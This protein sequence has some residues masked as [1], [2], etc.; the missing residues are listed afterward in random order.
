MGWFHFNGQFHPGWFCK[1][2]LGM[3][4]LGSCFVKPPSREWFHIKGDLQNDMWGCFMLRVICWNALQGYF[5][6]EDVL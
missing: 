2:T 3:V 1:T 4:S 6:G 5:H